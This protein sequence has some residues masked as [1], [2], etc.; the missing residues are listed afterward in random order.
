MPDFEKLLAAIDFAEE[1]AYGSDTDGE[2]SRDRAYSIRL[3]LGENVDP[4][5]EGRSQVV[6]RS[7][8][9]TIQW[10]LP[11]LCRVFAGGGD[12]VSIP[13]IGPDDEKGAQ[14]EAEYINWVMQQQNPWFETFITWATDALMT[15]NAYAMAYMDKQRVTET[16]KYERQTEDGVALLLQD[17][18][19]EV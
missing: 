5:P 11:S 13:P 18:D 19:V 1:N 16:E 10:I 2:L 6:D 9:E 14:Q 7:V 12:L 8:F 4:A 3:Y 15:R 17:K